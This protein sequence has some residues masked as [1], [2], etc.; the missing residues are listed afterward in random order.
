MLTVS[1]TFDGKRTIPS[2]EVTRLMAELLDLRSTDKLLEIGTGSGSQ[3]AVWAES[4]AEV[5]S[6]ELQPWID[7]TKITGECVFLYT[8][9][10]REGLAAHSPFSAIAACCGVEQIPRVWTEQLSE[11]GRLVAPIGDS[12]CQKLTLFRKRNGELIPERVG[13]YVKFQMLRKPP[14]LGKI[15]YQAKPEFSHS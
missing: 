5:H 3:T 10:G 14:K 13:A 6:I 15:P 8:G 11:H 7:S 4:G 12:T 9:D 1:P 2:P